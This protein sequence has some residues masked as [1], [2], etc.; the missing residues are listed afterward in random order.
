MD[1]SSQDRLK[2]SFLE[3]AAISTTLFLTILK[4]HKEKPGEPSTLFRYFLRVSRHVRQ[5]LAE[6]LRKL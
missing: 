3:S 2:Y 5:F 1:M 4:A 6:V